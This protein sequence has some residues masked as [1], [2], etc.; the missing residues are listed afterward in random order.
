MQFSM[1]QENI[2]GLAV[3]WRVQQGDDGCGEE[4]GPEPTG[5]A[6]N[7]P[8]SPAGWKEVEKFVTGMGGVP[9]D[10]ACSAQI[11]PVVKMFSGW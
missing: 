11:S 1:E 5:S 8:V 10:V 9:D 6:V 4:P 7:V 3:E 2:S